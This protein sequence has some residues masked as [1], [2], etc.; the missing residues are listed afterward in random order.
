MVDRH[1]F[2]AACAS[3]ALAACGGGA[4]TSAPTT[5]VP[6]FV[7][8]PD[9]A[10]VSGSLATTAACA[11][12]PPAGTLY[13]NAKV[14][15]FLAANPANPQNL[16]GVWQQNRWS[17]GAS[18]AVVS[19][20]SFDGGLT[21]TRT[22]APFSICTGGAVVNGGDFERASDPWVTFSPS[23][24]AYWMA[25][26]AT[27]GATFSAGS[28]S[29]MLVARSLDGGRT[30]ERP[31]TLIRDGA[32]AFNDKNSITADPTDANYVYAVWDRLQPSAG[33]PAWFART[34]N[35]GASWEAPRVLY[36]P[37]ASAQTLG[38]V[39]AVQP[40]GTL[41]NVFNRIT[42]LANNTQQSELE[43]M[44]SSDKG[45]N[46]SA[47]IKIAD[48]LAGGA[49]DPDTR[50]AIR[51]GAGLP[52]V[53]SAPNGSLYAVWQDGRFVNGIDSIAFARSTDGGRT[54]SA[55][56]RINGVAN[57][58]AFTPQISVLAD[59][60][61]GVTYF[62]LR[63]NTPDVNTL[64]AEL[65]LTRSRDGGA[66][67]SE[68][69]VAGPFDLAIAPNAR[70]LFLGDYQGLTAG[71]GRFI[72]LFAQTTRVPLTNPT[73]IFALA[74]TPPAQAQA[75]AQR[76]RTYRA[77]PASA[78]PTAEMRKRASENIVRV[79]ERRVPGWSNRM[80]PPAPR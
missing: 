58:Q 3:I 65:W 23:G 38:S 40:N 14:E 1:L 57:V 78:E 16:V 74:V 48:M 7:D 29:G 33:G 62:D 18:Q 72:S 22:T 47:P 49:F 39:I 31:I 71:G 5:P 34:A 42:T 26:T 50:T 56:V 36:D 59:G 28:E 12:L 30:W 79:L 13:P 80:K 70:G 77:Q 24:V 10:R 52:Q 75:A 25:L 60:T 35:G 55:P 73:D 45:V 61:I 53:A 27:G 32:L 20:A 67:W 37:G 4:G 64:P 6:Q 69:R 19:G 41:A 51:D 54:W 8:P 68:T 15:P 17:G 11:T 46:W 76:A 9:S 43:V 66:T 2:L 63:S 44:L 21:W